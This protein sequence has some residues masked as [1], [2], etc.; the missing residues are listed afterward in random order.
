MFAPSNLAGASTV[1][2]A[3]P[4]AAISTGRGRPSTR[5][6]TPAAEVGLP[7]ASCA[8]MATA[9]RRRCRPPGGGGGRDRQL[10]GRARPQRRPPCRRGAAASPGAI[11][12][13]ATAPLPRRRGASNRKRASPSGTAPERMQRARRTR[14]AS[15]S[16]ALLGRAVGLDREQDDLREA[17]DLQRRAAPAP[18]RGRTAAA[19]GRPRSRGRRRCDRRRARCRRARR[20][21]RGSGSRRGPVDRR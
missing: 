9:R 6:S 13:S 1:S 11:A 18:P 8:E 10:R 17:A 3:R 4:P 2:V 19:A 12:V 15:A 14:S 5:T 20:A 21:A 16:A 7:K